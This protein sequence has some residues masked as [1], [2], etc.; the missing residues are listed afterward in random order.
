VAN[1]FNTDTLLQIFKDGV[2]PE[3]RTA[4][5]MAEVAEV[6]TSNAEFVHYRFGADVTAE[7][8]TDGTYSTTDFTYTDDTVQADKEA[9]VAE[10][11][12]RTEFS[13]QGGNGGYLVLDRVDRHSRAIGVAAH[14]NAY[15]ETVDGAGLVL[16][17]EVLA[18]SA[19]AG[20]PITMSATN[21]DEVASKEYELLQD[22]GLDTTYGQ[23]YKMIDPQTA[24]FYKL[25]N[26]SNGFTNA[27]DQLRRGWQVVPLADFDYMITPEV[28]R[29]QVLSMA[30]NPTADDTVTVKGVTFTFK[31]SPAAAGEV[32]IGASADATRAILANA[33]NG[34][35]TGQ[36]SATGYIELSAA[37][38]KILKDAGVV[39]VNDDTANTL[40]VS[41]FAKISGAETFTDG[42]DAWGTE[43]KVLLSGIRRSTLLRLPSE[44][45]TVI[46]NDMLESDTGIQLRS[47]QQH[48]AGVWN[49]NA[50]KIVR[51]RVVG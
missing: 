14:R 35:A 34:S 21:P 29:E 33:I 46:K 50:N 30:T 22:V 42:T 28:E 11:V 23:P 49:K 18:G 3:I 9:V 36:G 19:S 4:I 38:R 37:N 20:T 51:T 48:G 26:M 40:T 13:E 31:A 6:D 47:S 1:T 17:N 5:P 15:R 7:N 27:D 16:D 45:L 8:T 39:A 32:D 25:F 43:R 24:R 44:G 2:Q 10:L 41:A 12:K